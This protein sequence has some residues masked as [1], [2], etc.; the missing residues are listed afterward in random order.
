[1][2]NNAIDLV[3]ATDDNYVLL[4][5]V[6]MVSVF[7]N[8]KEFKKIRVW[9][10]AHNLSE[11]MKKQLA[12]CAESYHREIQ[13]VDTAEYLKVIKATGA[14]GWGEKGSL[15]AYSRLFIANIM[16]KY[17]INKVL[18]CDCD[19]IIEGSLQPVWNYDL[20]GKVLGMVKEYNRLEI[21]DLLGLSR[22]A[23]YYQSGF[24]VMD[25]EKWQD[26]KCTERIIDHMKNVSSMYPFVDQDLI[27]CVLHD[28]ICTLPI[29]YNVN[30]RAMQYSYKELTY[31][32][33]LNEENYYTEEE[34]D[35]GIR[36]GNIPVV[37]H[38]SDPIGGKP[39]QQG[40]HHFFRDKW[41]HYY[42]NS[43]WCNLYSKKE[44]KPVKIAQI[45]W[46]LYKVLPR[47]IYIFILHHCSKVAMKKT[48]KNFLV[49]R[50]K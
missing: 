7:E 42:Y 43:M 44:Y 8:N 41:D 26:K 21:R 46:F 48:V 36:S 23:S 20:N 6:S 47:N 2:N 3:W 9:I 29:Q 33:G 49:Y 25:I 38:C 13:F 40:N 31:I 1:M 19:L 50:K 39:W 27:N 34:F 35:S 28:E 24:L 5:G 4:T 15:S 37:Y 45:Q 22:N 10:L 14:L 30:P 18:Y 12:E 17:G 32:Y 11:D 16:K